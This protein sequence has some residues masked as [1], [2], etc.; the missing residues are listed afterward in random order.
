[1][2]RKK[3]FADISAGLVTSTVSLAYCFS[4]GALIFAGPLQPFLGQGVAAALICSGVIGMIASVKSGFQVSVSG[5]EGNTAALVAAMMTALAPLLALQ[6]D[7][8]ALYL[9]LAA[10][11]AVTV[12]TGVA[13]YFL[14]HYRL[15]RLA[16]FI[17]YPVLAGFQAASGW[18]MATGAIRM[19]TGVPVHLVTLSSFLTGE[20]AAML[21]VTTA[22][23][24]VLWQLTVRIKHVLTLP[25]ALTVAALVTDLVFKMAPSLPVSDWMFPMSRGMQ[26]T[27]PILDP[28][29]W[30]VHWVSLLGVSGE[31]AA[32]AMMA[33]LTITLTATSIEEVWRIDIDL[34][35]ELKMHGVAN[36]ASGLLGG[37]VGHVV[38]NR[39]FMAREA[40]GSG[41]ATGLVVGIIGLAALGSRLAMIGYV[42]RFVLGGLLLELGARL[43]WRWCITGRKRLALLEWLLV[44]AILAV[45]AWFGVL[46]G[47]LIGILGGC[48]IFVVSVSRVDIV[49][50]RFTVD[51]RPSSL[52]RSSEETELIAAHGGE[53]EI[54]QLATFIFF[55]QAYRLQERIRAL[56]EVKAP[57]MVIFDFS[58]VTG[59]DSSAGSSLLRIEEMLNHRGITHAVVGLSPD[60]SHIMADA[61]GLGPGVIRHDSLDEALECGED[62][63]LARHGGHATGQRPLA[64]W[65]AEALGSADLAGTLAAALEPANHAEAGYLCRAGDPTD[66]LLFIESG[67]VSVEVDHDGHSPIRQRVFG[68]NTIVGEVGFFLGVPRTASL[69]IDGPATV[70]TLSHAMYQRLSR[71]APAVTAALLTCTV[72][73]QAERLAFSSRQVTALQR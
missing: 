35:R 17:P 66:T 57:R 60:V 31:I 71:E 65:L 5:P 39:T 3:L 19:S 25:I 55:G 47:F 49:K 69:R 26:V 33:A 8:G 9:A 36:I 16:R 14:G 67:R 59:I 15:G 50:H 1:M 12:G 68:A 73:I 7:M 48:V 45:T 6:P 32:V 22:W 72:R 34:D 54:V 58:A 38:L 43:V 42:P 51:E 41:R 61:G 29:V 44:L 13:L 27:L 30:H 70:W 64:D 37:M 62:N 10:L 46:I 18:I 53:V 40:G 56:V 52:V 2:Q 20:T 63:I 24:L 4:F 28:G 21:A 23:A 11:T